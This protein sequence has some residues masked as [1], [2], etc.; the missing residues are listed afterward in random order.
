MKLLLTAFEPFGGN[1][2]NITEQVLERIETI[3]EGCELSK[4]ILPVSYSRAPISL[5]R[6]I[7][8]VHP[9]AILL[10]GQCA[11]S[12]K[13][14][15][16]RF[17][18]NMM[19]SSKNDNDGISHFE[20]IIYPYS[21]LALRTTFQLHSMVEN[22]ISAP[23]P[24]IISNSAGLY[25]CNCAYYEALYNNPQSVFIHIPRNLDVEQAQSTILQIAQHITRFFI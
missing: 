5:R 22:I 10:L 17:A 4:L 3:G 19:D 7:E 8:N 20:Q 13:N 15:L 11:A 1:T 6:A 9:D 23:I 16:E 14:R 25:V 21:P 12:E 24:L 18:I 2:T